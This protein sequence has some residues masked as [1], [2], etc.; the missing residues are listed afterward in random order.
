MQ[1]TVVPVHW[2]VDNEGHM[3]LDNFGLSELIKG[4]T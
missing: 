1:E 2:N 4:I 3:H